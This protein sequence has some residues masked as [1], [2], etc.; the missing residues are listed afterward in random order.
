MNYGTQPQAGDTQRETARVLGI[1]GICHDLAGQI[2][3][4]IGL[5]HTTLWGPSPP[6]TEKESN[7]KALGPTGF[8][9][10]VL[11]ILQSLQ[12][13]LQ[14]LNDASRPLRNL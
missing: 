14:R 1:L 11:A 6:T 3:E 7:L 8:L 2:E 12:M 13:R 5:A 9:P 4:S 10:D